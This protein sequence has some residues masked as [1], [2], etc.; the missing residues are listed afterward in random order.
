MITGL[1]REVWVVGCTVIAF[2]LFYIMNYHP[3]FQ[4]IRNTLITPWIPN[5]YINFLITYILIGAP[6]FLSVWMIHR[7]PNILMPLG[8]SKSL[9]RG[10]LVGFVF[11][12]PTLIGHGLAAGWQ[13]VPTDRIT[14]ALV[15]GVGAGVFE[16]MYF[17]GFLF[18]NIFRN[19]RIGFVPI[20]LITSITF[21]FIH[22]TQTYSGTGQLVGILS[23]TTLGSALFAWLYVE[24]D[25]NLWVPISVHGLMDIWWNVFAAGQNAAGSIESDIPR[26]LVGVVAIVI[27]IAYKRSKSIPFE[28]NRRTWWWRRNNLEVTNSCGGEGADAS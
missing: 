22:I 9:S 7:T 25:Y 28:V 27:T 4:L 23:F 18:G 8:L 17:R 2:S 1:R 10:F 16:E 3:D 12:L 11:T 15:D 26:V 14:G 19:T 24:W 6:V 5:N 21:A 13:V 20:I